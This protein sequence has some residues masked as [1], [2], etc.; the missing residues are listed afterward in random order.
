MVYPPSEDSYFL[1]EQVKKHISN[2][3]DKS[4]IKVLDMG[5]GSGIQA[6]EAIKAGIPAKNIVCADIDKEAVKQLKKQ[7]LEAIHSDLFSKILKS[8]KFNLIIFN[9][10][11]LPEDEYDKEAD[12]TAG[13][14]GYETIT[15]FLKQAKVHLAEKGIILLLFSSLSRPKI[16]LKEAESLGYNFKLLAEKSVGFFER[17]FVYK[18]NM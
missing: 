15:R 17:L 1:E 4:K 7:K 3:K 9:P 16:I 11:Y 18:L 2:I 5:S 6:K 8:N 12:T 10:P 14:R 13:K